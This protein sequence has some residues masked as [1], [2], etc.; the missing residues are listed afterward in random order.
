MKATTA[1]IAMILFGFVST[2]ALAEGKDTNTSKCP[3]GAMSRIE[4]AAM[5]A[6]DLEI[7]QTADSLLKNAE[8]SGAESKRDAELSKQ[9]EM[10]MAS[11]EAGKVA[12]E[13][14]AK[15]EEEAK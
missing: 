5:N 4:T 15:F 7:S 12:E 3:N 14:M 2:T 6:L 9:F 1:T 13:L 11:V 10:T 8:S